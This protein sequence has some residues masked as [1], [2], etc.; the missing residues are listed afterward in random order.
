MTNC[1]SGKH[2]EF[3]SEILNQVDVVIVL[4]YIDRCGLSC[5]KFYCAAADAMKNE[6]N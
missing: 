4:N 3:P 2:P 6:L 1:T 5:E